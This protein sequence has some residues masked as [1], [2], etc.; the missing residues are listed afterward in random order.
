M[1]GGVARRLWLACACLLAAILVARVEEGQA[2]RRSF[3]RLQASFEAIGIGLAP[4]GGWRAT[5]IVPPL[6]S[7]ASIRIAGPGRGAATGHDARL[8][9][10]VLGAFGPAHLVVRSIE[11]AWPGR[12]A[13]AEAGRVVVGTLAI[14]WSATRIS[15]EADHVAI[16]AAAMLASVQLDLRCVPDGCCL[17]AWFR[18]GPT[19]G[20]AALRA[21][22]AGTLGWSLDVAP[23]A[24][25]HALEARGSLAMS[26]TATGDNYVGTAALGPGWSAAL[27]WLAHARLITAGERVASAGLLGFLADPAGR[28]TLPLRLDPAGLFVGRYRIVDAS[29]LAE[30]GDGALAACWR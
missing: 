26:R 10:S 24:G 12:G 25:A 9:R 18:V 16:G 3:T 11:G 17:L 4:D 19:V 20:H 21:N 30:G 8:S 28:V 1:T 2:L 27:D 7:A 22:A 13:D 15:G 14:S 5:G 29:F 23:D 6:L